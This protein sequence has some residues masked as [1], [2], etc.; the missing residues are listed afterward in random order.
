MRLVSQEKLIIVGGG[1]GVGGVGV[2]VAVNA[3]EAPVGREI[4]MVV[5]LKKMRDV[6]YYLYH[7]KVVDK[8]V[9]LM[10]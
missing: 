3:V 8:Y 6:G 2:V 7:I 10:K 4:R 9:N 5:V 1:V